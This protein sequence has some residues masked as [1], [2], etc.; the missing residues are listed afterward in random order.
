[1]DRLAELGAE[2]KLEVHLGNPVQVLADRPLATTFT[3]VP[4]WRRRSPSLDLAEVH[5]W[6]WLERPKAGSVASFSAWSR[7]N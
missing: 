4:G 3:P 1:V 6:P 5:P 2:R 7:V